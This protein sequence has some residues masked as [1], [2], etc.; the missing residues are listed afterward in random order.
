MKGQNNSTPTMEDIEALA[1]A[2]KNLQQEKDGDEKDINI[3]KQPAQVSA[4]AGL[5]IYHVA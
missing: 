2:L 4:V 3:T 1:S 5:G